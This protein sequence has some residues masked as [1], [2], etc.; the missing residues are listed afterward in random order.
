MS[1]RTQHVNVRMTKVSHR[2][3][4]RLRDEFD[5]SIPLLLER[6]V[7]HAEKSDPE[8]RRDILVPVRGR[9]RQ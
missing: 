1:N 2:A 5:L 3:A 8:S 4:R 6:L 7:E 9:D